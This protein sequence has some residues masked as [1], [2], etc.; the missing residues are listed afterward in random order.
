MSMRTPRARNNGVAF[1]IDGLELSAPEGST[2]LEAADAAGVK[3][4]R[5]CHLAGLSDA[6][7]CRLCLVE[8]KGS[9]RLQ[10]ACMVKVRDELE[11][12][13]HS[14]RLNRYRRMILELLFAERNHICAVCVASGHC[15]LQ[16]LAAE[17]GM[18]HVRFPYRHPDL[19][20]DA[21]HARF[22][23]DPNRCVLCTRCVRVCSE[24]EGAN[25]WG[26]MGRGANSLVIT[27]LAEPWGQAQSCTSCSKCVQ[28]CPTG[29]LFEK[30]RAV[31]EMSTNP[32]FLERLRAFR[33]E[34]V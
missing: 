1:T 12:T 6:G 9:P 8:L 33:K 11:V 5:L 7:A 32:E 13:V 26:V 14:E 28:V 25:T 10:P 20:V 30:G 16:T 15:E 22:A 31:G 24:I 3:I 2:L 27:D 23:L 4:P 29:A 19:S 21:S 34:G 18:D 17:L